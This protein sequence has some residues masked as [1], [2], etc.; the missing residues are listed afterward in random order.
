M[1]LPSCWVNAGENEVVV[2]EIDDR[3]NRTMSG[4]K[5]PILDMLQE[6]KNRP[7][8]KQRDG[9]YPWLDAGDLMAEVEL[10]GGSQPQDVKFKHALTARHIC[11]EI[12][13][14]Q[15]DQAFSHAAEIEVL[16]GDGQVIP[17]KNWKIWFA[18][19]EEMSAE[20]GVA[21]NLIDGKIE[22]HWHS[23]YSGMPTKF[24]H[25]IVIDTGNIG[26]I[27]AIRYVGRPGNRG[28][29]KKVRVYARPQFFLDQ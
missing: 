23:V 27:S 14:S 8:A 13:S 19:S 12:L 15:Q 4:L 18:N 3:G 21:E 5:Q 25:V 22:T 16:D 29:I 11:L 9:K 6:D 17:K 28:G 24:P 2:L 26:S 1:Y 20:N 7:T 10:K